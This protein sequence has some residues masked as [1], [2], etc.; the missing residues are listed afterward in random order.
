MNKQLKKN[1]EFL[2]ELIIKVYNPNQAEINYL[3]NIKDDLFLNNCKDELEKLGLIKKI[4]ISEANKNMEII[5]NKE[6]ND[7]RVKLVFDFLSKLNLSEKTLTHLR[8]MEYNEIFLN[9]YPLEIIKLELANDLNSDTRLNNYIKDIPNICLYSKTKTEIK[10]LAEKLGSQKLFI[11]GIKF[12]IAEYHKEILD[13]IKKV[14]TN[15]NTMN[16]Y[17][18]SKYKTHSDEYWDFLSEIHDK[19]LTELNMK[20]YLEEKFKSNKIELNV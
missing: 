14:Q 17:S 5:C 13:I 10:D 18:V 15:Y 9:N 12:F 16:F 8:S 1:R 3:N 7:K 11:F 6:L 20:A 2:M 19:L 4:E